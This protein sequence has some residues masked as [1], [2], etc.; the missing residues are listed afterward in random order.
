MIERWE[1]T[2]AVLNSETEPYLQYFQ[3]RWPQMQLSYNSPFALLPQLEVYG[4]QGW[5]L[6]A[7]QPVILGNNGEVLISA[8][9]GVHRA[10]QYLCTFKRRVAVDY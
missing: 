2:M 4:Q 5:E 1:Y 7:V 8:Q 6:V 3:Q 10:T 9:V